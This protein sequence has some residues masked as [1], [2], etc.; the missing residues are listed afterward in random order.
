MISGP[1]PKTLDTCGPLIINKNSC[2]C[3]GFSNITAELYN[4]GFR[5]W[6][7]GDRSVDPKGDR[8]PR[9]R[10]PVLVIKQ[11]QVFFIRCVLYEESFEKA[12][13]ILLP[14]IDVHAWNLML[15]SEK[16]VAEMI[17]PSG[18]A[19]HHVFDRWEA[20]YWKFL[21]NQSRFYLALGSV[22]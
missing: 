4:K 18:V 5:S 11:N 16:F 22:C 8:G 3:F 7:L 1:L 21:P 6:P 19:V 13:H 9:L 20:H 10:N 12:R 15:K 17:E 14:F 2:L